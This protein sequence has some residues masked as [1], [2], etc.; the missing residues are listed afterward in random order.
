MYE[1]E[2]RVGKRRS[3]ARREGVTRRRASWLGDLSNS[4]LGHPRNL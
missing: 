3:R 4:G 1:Y 2:E